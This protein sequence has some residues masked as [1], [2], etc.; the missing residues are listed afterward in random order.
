MAKPRQV[1]VKNGPIL[2]EY[3][4]QT[5]PLGW[6]GSLRLDQ[7]GLVESRHMLRIAEGWMNGP[8]D[9]LTWSPGSIFMA[10]WIEQ[11]AHHAGRELRKSRK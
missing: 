2:I 1:E 5:L 6:I 9:R 10:A 4:Y 7:K 3:T 8:E 11:F